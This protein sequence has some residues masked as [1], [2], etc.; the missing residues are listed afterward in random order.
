M[1]GGE[2]GD[3]AIKG[4]YDRPLVGGM[5]GGT[6]WALVAVGEGWAGKSSRKPRRPR[7]YSRGERGDS[8][9]CV[10]GVSIPQRDSH[11]P[12]QRLEGYSSCVSDHRGG[13]STIYCA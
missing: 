12:T 3:S 6:V 8:A 13:F 1:G 10:A 9:A 7:P 11:A 4:A 2:R 5:K